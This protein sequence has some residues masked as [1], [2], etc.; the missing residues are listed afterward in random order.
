MYNSNF[1]ER[2]L[3]L[4]EKCEDQV[5]VDSAQY[6]NTVMNYRNSDY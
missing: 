4:N 5:Y 3:L 6:W 2:L 1:Y